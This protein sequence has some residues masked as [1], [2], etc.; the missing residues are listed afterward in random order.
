MVTFVAT[1]LLIPTIGTCIDGAA[2]YW[3]KAR[4]SAAVDASALATARSLN[5]GQTVADQETAARQVGAQY[6]TANFPTG[7]MQ[8]TV[9][10]GAPTIA[11]NE[12]AV[13]MRIVTVTASA[14][15]P[16]FFMRILGFNKSTVSASGQATRRDSNIMLVLDRSNSM[17]NSSGS[18]AS[19]AGDALSFVNQFVEGR[20]R[21]GL[22]TFQTGAKVDFPP[23]LTFKASLASA[24]G[25]LR[26]A[27]DTSTAQGLYLAYDQI[28]NTINQ[29][30]ALNVILLFTDGEPNGVVA[31]FNI[32]TKTDT[33]YDPQNTSQMD[34]NMGP[35]SCPGGTQLKGVIA[36][37]SLESAADVTG[38]N[39]TGYTVA[40]L[41]STGV[42]I[43]ST[44]DPT[45]I[46][47]NGCAFSNSN[48]QYSIFG[49][50]DI[51]AI[52][53]QDANGYSTADRPNLMPALDRFPLSN[54]NYHGLIR[55]DMPR[56]VRWASFN[57]AD[58]VAQAIRNDLTYT[59]VIYTIGETGHEPMAM[60]QDFM[61]RLA[62]DGTGAVPA[63]NFDATK[64][65]GRFIL[66]NNDAELAQAFQQI[67]SQIL[68]LSQ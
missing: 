12:T 45:T 16:T 56:T 2:L 55:P 29:P 65:Q 35:S 1:F 11:I 8:A 17:N 27:G 30:G 41:D 18:C 6:F 51:A 24:L 19:M 53:E 4:L 48:W 64:P 32:K 15:V 25:S 61:K 68:R 31:K 54:A 9:A 39:Q 63:S 28:K 43:S 3:V 13:H 66:A 20:D 36:D 7:V 23:A 38:L 59:T 33:R 57:A 10:G 58:S 14:T 67:A 49:R 46:S 44:A 21:V 22:V 52:P 50:T 5:V 26:C 37:G 60:D 42:P 62:N 40:V 34:N 47:A